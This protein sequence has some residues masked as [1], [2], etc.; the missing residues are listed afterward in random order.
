MRTV[1]IYI[2]LFLTGF[3]FSQSDSLRNDS[4]KK[5]SKKDIELNEIEIVAEK[6]NS[7]GISRLNNVEGTTIYA[8]KKTEAI[9]LQDLNANLAANNSRQV[10][11]KIAG[12]NIFE[13]DG[14]GATIGIGGRGLNP[15]RISNFNTRQ[16]GYDISADALG[17]PESY[18][19]PPTEAIER[20]EILR[21]AAGLQFG[22]QFGGMINYK[23]A[24]AP[25][26]K[27]LAAKFRQTGGS[28]GFINSFNQIGGTVKKLSYNTFYQY[29][30]YSGW[31]ERSQLH[32]HTAF[33]SLKYQFNERF[34]IKG[35][36][37]F[38]SYL[39]Q[40]PGGLTDKQ[41][42]KDPTIVNRYRNW[43]KV[44]WN[45]FSLTADYKVSDRGRFNFMFFGLNAGRD[46]LGNLG[47]IDRTD[48]TAI[49]RN[50][51][52]D[53]YNNYGGELRFLQRYILCEN[54]SHFLIGTRIYKGHT[55]RKQGDADK[56]DKSHFKFLNPDNLENSAYVFPSSNYALFIENIFQLT[57]K[58]SVTPGVR[59][60]NI[61]TSSEGYYRLLNKDL[62]GN[63]LLDMKVQ[64]NR[65][66]NRSFMLAG[67]GTQLKLNKSVELYAN[68]SQNYRSINFNDMRVLNP[69]FQVDPNL[70]DESGYTAD[71]GF[72]GVVKNILYFDVSGFYLN[73]ENRIGTV[74]RVDSS[75]YNILRYR[76]NISDSKNTGVEAFGEIDWL[77]LINKNSKHKLSTFVNMSYIN[78]I[79]VSSQQNAYNNKKVE[80]VP[81]VI[82]RTGLTYANKKFSLTYQYSYTAQQFSDADNSLSTS[83]A[84]Y[85]IIPAYSIMDIS[86]NYSW[87]FLGF[88]AG[89]N[90]LANSS[91]FTRRAEGYPG[92]GIMPADPINA[93]FTIQVKL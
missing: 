33:A 39:A 25:G 64:D 74:L 90:N 16:N 83:S 63:I 22:T 89:V 68:F 43:F 59:F 93:Y 35:E 29:K 88:S 15:N 46:A 71:G 61:V 80:Y 65:S 14:S 92:P 4:L 76:T 20:I 48:D 77:K 82:F 85:G 62:A 66:N 8:G 44:N 38:L 58:W 37:T 9:Y 72:R 45:L 84:I 32:S 51:L 11:S 28:F 56:T 31:R 50:L 79:Y 70:K 7:F 60:E 1:L 30:Q 18:Y 57:K 6:D 10:F 40:Q 75:T 52:S 73:Y 26:D 3:V 55:N 49:Y 36:Y 2:F 21:G 23:F 5:K 13:N 53:V 54:N 12:I 81:D 67:I 42:E 78:A 87:R 41:F 86:A 27:K 69:N 24:E 34:F 19:T 47:R 17:Y 91:Y